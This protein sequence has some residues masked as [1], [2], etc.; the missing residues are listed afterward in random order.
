MMFSNPKMF[1]LEAE[2]LCAGSLFE[3]ALLEYLVVLIEKKELR[4]GMMGVIL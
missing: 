4:A 3:G 1:S 2:G